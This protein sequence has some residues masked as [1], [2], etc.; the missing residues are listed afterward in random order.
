[1]PSHNEVIIAAAGG[2]KTTRIVERAVGATHERAALVTYTNNNADE[3][4]RAILRFRPSVPQHLEVMTWYTFLLH[5]LAR[6]YQNAMIDKRIEGI[7]FVPGHSAIGVPRSNKC[8]FYFA[9]GMLIYSDKISDFVCRSNEASGKAVM[10]RLQQRFDR[11]YI[12]EVQDLAGYDL[13][14]VDMILRS[15]I[16]VTLVGDHR[17]STFRTHHSKRNI[18]FAGRDIVKKFAEWESEGLLTRTTERETW[19]SCQPIADL[20]DKFFPDEPTTISKNEKDTG[21]DGVFAIPRRAVA[22]YVRRYKPFIL[23]LSKRT[24]TEGLDAMNYGLSKG[25]TVDRVLIFPHGK[26]ID[27]LKS[28]DFKHVE[29][30]A[31]EMYVGITRARYSVTFVIDDDVGVPGVAPYDVCDASK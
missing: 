13:D 5:D 15:N 22:E 27:W 8:R 17:Q 14:V 11:I 12:D 16:K 28:N 1:M 10:R 18:Q 24:D 26:A 30:T 20:A 31:E 2:R 4:G 23:R 19:R 7:S 25:L 6:P 29:K 21:H 9:N 3:L